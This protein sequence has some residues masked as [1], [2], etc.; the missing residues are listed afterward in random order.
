ML[1]SYINIICML[2]HII[3]YY[4]Y[5]IFCSIFIHCIMVYFL[6]AVKRFSDGLGSG[7]VSRLTGRAC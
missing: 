1:I 6:V 4:I 5:I 2:H 7:Q 3:L